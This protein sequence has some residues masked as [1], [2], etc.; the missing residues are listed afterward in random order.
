MNIYQ[1]VILCCFSQ[2]KFVLEET[3]LKNHNPY[4]S[5]NVGGKKRE[6][7]RYL[8]GA[9]VNEDIKKRM[10]EISRPKSKAFFTLTLPHDN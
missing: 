5:R 9:A 8:T 7:V 6:K 2:F 4:S 10:S 3:Y 1:S